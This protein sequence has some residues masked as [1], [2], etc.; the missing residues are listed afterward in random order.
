MG[1]STPT[2]QGRRLAIEYLAT[3]ALRP[4]PKNPRRHSAKQ[5]GKLARLIDEF[6]WST[7]MVVDENNGVLA[8]HG[9]L[10]AAKALNL[11]QVPCVRLSHLSEAKKTALAIADNAMS[12]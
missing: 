2:K 6:G 4:N 9:R 8:G 5:V 10:E 12:D 7:P 11:P 3:T 1:R